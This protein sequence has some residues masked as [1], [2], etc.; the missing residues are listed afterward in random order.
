MK[1]W[2]QHL[3]M[4]PQLCDTIAQQSHKRFQDVLYGLQLYR[5]ATCKRTY[6]PVTT[7]LTI[8]A[9]RLLHYPAAEHS[10][11]TPILFLIPSLI[12]RYYIMDLNEQ[13]SLVRYFAAQG[14]TC[15]LL[16][17]GDPAQFEMGFDCAAYIHFILQP[18]LQHLRSI[19]PSNPITLVGHCMGGILAAG[20]A[21]QQPATSI[22]GLA[23]L[24]TPWDFSPQATHTA[25]LTPKLRTM[26]ENTID[27]SPRFS[28]EHMLTLFYLRDPWLFQD[29][30]RLLPYITD[31]EKQ[32]HF[33]EL[34]NWANDCVD[35]TQGVARDCLIHW[36]AENHLMRGRWQVGNAP[37]TPER[38]RA[39]PL[40]FAMPQQDKIV[41]PSSTTPLAK[42]LAHAH[43]ITPSSGHVG[44]LVGTHAQAQLWQPLK[45]WMMRNG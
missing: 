15:Y 36:G 45:E 44:M 6:L 14:I 23:L 29:K 37:L 12:N 2:L 21:A 31:K 18:M 42:A 38:L 39:L 20:L 22:A 7:T 30:L 5:S 24:A 17:W 11:N 40:F 34:S 16:D 26:L 10:T 43:T 35:L 3:Q 32:Q 9:A 8:G 19:H 25:P 13:R 28:G 4:N 27:A 41:P 1:A 33:I